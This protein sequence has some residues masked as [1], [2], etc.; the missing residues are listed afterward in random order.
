MR[1]YKGLM[2]SRTF[3]DL[4]D[5]RAALRDA[6]E[7]QG[8]KD[9]AMENDTAKEDIDLID[10][11]LQMVRGASAY[12]LVIGRSYGQTPLCPSRNPSQLSITELEFNEAH[13]QK[14]ILLFIMG[15]KHSLP[16]AD[17]ESDPGKLAKL[18]A[19][20]ERAKLQKPDS[21]VHRV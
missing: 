6:I 15:E 13:G 3:A 10:S 21:F 2:I 7:R 17:V 20:R 5:H 8:F 18:N 16:E 4:K 1:L 12:I 19:F 9:V 11:S 14:P